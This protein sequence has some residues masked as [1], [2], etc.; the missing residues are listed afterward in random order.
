MRAL[1]VI[2]STLWTVFAQAEELTFTSGPQQTSLLELYASEGCSSCPPAE[3]WLSRLEN[4]PRLWREFVP[5]AYAVDYWDDLGWRDPYSN[6]RWSARQR[7]YNAAGSVSSVYTPAF[8]INGEE[9]RGW[10]SR[11]VL[12]TSTVK[13]GVLKVALDDGDIEARFSPAPNYAGPWV[14][15]AAILGFGITSDISRGENA[16]KTLTHDFLVLD[17]ADSQP[18]NGQWRMKLPAL[19][20]PLAKKFGLAVWVTKMGDIMPVQA[21]GGLMAE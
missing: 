10:F 7:G 21:T 11:R 17:Q 16:G 3:E 1:F 20:Q 2:I 19:T 6:K 14:L 5:V 4:D 12:P 13:V 8:V 15:H 18:S 9:W